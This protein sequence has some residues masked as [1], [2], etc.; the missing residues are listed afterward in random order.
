MLPSLH[1]PGEGTA[2]V[3]CRTGQ[4]LQVTRVPHALSSSPRILLSP[5]LTPDNKPT[6]LDCRHKTYECVPI[7]FLSA[8]TLFHDVLFL[9]LPFLFYGNFY[10][11]LNSLVP[12]NVDETQSLS[13]GNHMLFLYIRFLLL[14]S[15]THFFSPM[16]QMQRR[17]HPLLLYANTLSPP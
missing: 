17:A 11:S 10:L 6:L 9:H 8:L 1:H 16:H 13:C 14:V 2:D 7:S 15:F 3:T 5:S 4:D 12:E